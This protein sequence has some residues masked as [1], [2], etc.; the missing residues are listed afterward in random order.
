[1]AKTPLSLSD[2][3]NKKGRPK[4]WCLFIQD[5]LIYAGAGLL[6]PVTGSLKLMPGTAS[7]PAYR[8][9][10]VDTESGNILGLY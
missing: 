8:H 3:P 7:D 4:G 1:M 2:N 9:I 10:D 5:I 6:V